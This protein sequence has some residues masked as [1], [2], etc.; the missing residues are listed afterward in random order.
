[1]R[2]MLLPRILLYK[3]P[4]EYALTKWLEGDEVADERGGDGDSSGK[5]G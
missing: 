3:Q 5:T 4:T 1:M 2:F